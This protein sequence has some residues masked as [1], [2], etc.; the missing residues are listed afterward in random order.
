MSTYFKLERVCAEC[1]E[2]FWGTRGAQFCS[3]PCRARQ[4]RRSNAVTQAESLADICKEILMRRTGG[5]A[6]YSKLLPRLF[7]VTAAELRKRGWD[8]IELLLS[9]PDDPASA[10]DTAPGGIEGQSPRRRKWLHPPER[11][12]ELL[13]E[14]IEE[15]E[16]DG[17]P[18]DWHRARVQQLEAILAARAPRTKPTRPRVLKHAARK[19]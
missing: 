19:R 5:S 12:L 14:K 11:E 18:A 1:G 4:W 6:S 10:T 9:I 3:S 7:R 15:R 13:K 8:P 16:E 17:L 2:K